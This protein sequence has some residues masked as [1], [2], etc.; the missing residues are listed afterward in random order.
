MNLEQAEADIRKFFDAAWTAAFASPN[1]PPIAW[2][3]IEFTIPENKTWV[4]FN[5]QENGGQ[6][7]GMGD[8]GN[9]RFRRFGIVTIQV[10]Q[11]RGQGSK[12][13]RTKAAA[14]RD[15]F[16]GA[17]TTGGVTFQDVSARQVGDD[18]HGFYQ[19]NVFAPF[20]YDEIT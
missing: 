17:Q 13:A 2:P 6:Q 12:D 3:D 15:L 1:T 9:N 20:W 5:C 16:T 10:F 11:P 14:A 7:V 18:G 8:P 19:V 4:R